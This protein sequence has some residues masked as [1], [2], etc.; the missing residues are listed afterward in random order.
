VGEL[1]PL[2]VFARAPDPGRTKTRLIPALGEAGAAALHRA[3][4]DD[5]L[6]RC[7]G[8][9]GFETTLWCA[10]NPD[11]PVLARL[12]A[13]HGV[14]REPQPPGDLGARMAGALGAALARA[15]RGLLIGTDAPTL[16]VSLLHTAA[17][18]LEQAELVLGPAAD[19]GY[20]LVGVRGA[21]PPVFEGVP[22]SSPRVLAATLERARTAGVRTALLPPWYDVDRAQDLRL[23][24][25]HLAL[26]PSAAP[27]T[28]AAVH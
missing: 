2:A 1:I 13:A 24:R 10:G 4:I 22:W 25:S 19:G 20:Y 3:F 6:A 8:A 12:A 18:G 17:R 28:A 27:A 21:V 9:A 14:A 26:A 5:T 15:G 11:H 16:P 7:A 23:L